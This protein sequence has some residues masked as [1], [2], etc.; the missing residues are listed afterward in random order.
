[1]TVHLQQLARNKVEGSY[2]KEVPLIDKRYMNGV[3]LQ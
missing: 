1:M 3:L 2:V